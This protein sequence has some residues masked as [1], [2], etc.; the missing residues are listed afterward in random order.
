MLIYALV[1]LR[2]IRGKS[3]VFV[4]TIERCYKYVHSLRSTVE[5]VFAGFIHILENLE[6]TG[7][8]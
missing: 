7:I 4:N 2:L 8:S 6:N 5:G 3:I 1:K